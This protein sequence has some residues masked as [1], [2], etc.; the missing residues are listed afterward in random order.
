M[1]EAGWL[2]APFSLKDKRIWVAG[3]GGLVGSALCRRLALED[4]EV[5][6]VEKAALDCRDALAVGQWVAQNQPDIILIAAAKVGGIQANLDTPVTF[7][8]DNMLIAGTILQAAQA[9]NVRKVLFLGSSCIYPK[10]A[11]SPIREEMLGTGPLEPSNAS[12]AL[13]KIAGIKMCQDY[14]TQYGCD[15][16]AAMPCNLYGPG[17]TYDL[18]RSHVIPALLMKAHAAVQSG[19]STLEIWGSGTPRREFLYSDDLADGLVFLLKRYSG[20]MPVN[21]GAGTDISI[22]DLAEKI[23]QATGFEGALIFNTDRPDGV[24]RKLMDSSRIRAAGWQPQTTLED[25]LQ[26]AY[27]WYLNNALSRYAA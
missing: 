10:T 19:A 27:H 24:A 26:K 4:C 11:E 2:R 15:F 23:C 18:E 1:A 9:H 20:A 7:F 25:G 16:I 14:R 22:R 5:L 17:D 21:I 3:H 13:A 12:Y 8:R 6:T